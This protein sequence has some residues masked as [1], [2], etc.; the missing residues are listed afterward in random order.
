MFTCRSLYSNH[1]GHPGASHRQSPGIVKQVVDADR[2]GV[3]ISLGE[4]L[5]HLGPVV[6]VDLGGLLD[7]IL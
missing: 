2:L 7:I 3:V 5:Q 4:V 1:S 6:H